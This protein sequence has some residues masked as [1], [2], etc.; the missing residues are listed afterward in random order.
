MKRI[1]FVYSSN[2][3]PCVEFTQSLQACVS[4][5]AGV[6]EQRNTVDL[7]MARNSALTSAFQALLTGRH[8]VVLM[9]DDDM[10][11]KPQDATR[12]SDHV[13][14][15][16]H[17]ASAA[18]VMK[19]GRLA[20]HYVGPRWRCGLGFLAIP[21]TEIKRLSSKSLPYAG[22]D[23][24]STLEF[25]RS[26]VIERD[27]RRVWLPEDYCLSERLG[28][29]DLLPIAVGHVKSVVL[30]PN[31]SKLASFISKSESGVQE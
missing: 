13:R 24:A 5:G 3:T 30:S 10:Q 11:W 20:A 31:E 27:G 29:V 25:T 7:A 16:G 22:A 1:L 2:R 28:G 12:I 26:G 17:A 23:G 15:S 4:D 14:A 19:D 8:D 6:I 18:Y 9:V 21:A